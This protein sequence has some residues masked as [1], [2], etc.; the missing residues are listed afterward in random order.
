MPTQ[1]YSG[2]A[3]RSKKNLFHRH[4]VFYQ[5]LSPFIRVHPRLICIGPSRVTANYFSVAA[6]CREQ[7]GRH[8]DG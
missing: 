4:I 7:N 2:G 8:A 1:S 5:L 6:V 3:T